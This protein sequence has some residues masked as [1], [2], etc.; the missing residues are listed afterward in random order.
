M[1]N[2]TFNGNTANDDGDG[3]YNFSSSSPTVTNCILWGDSAP[4]G[5]EIYSYSGCTPEV[6]YSCIQGI[7]IPVSGNTGSNPLFVNAPTNVR[8][9]AGS[10]CIDT[11][12]PNGAPSIDIL[13]VTRPQGNGYDMGAY[14][15]KLSIIHLP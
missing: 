2:C 6:T 12:T 9:Q 13:G 1:T 10:P 4:S 11:G 7:F 14:E 5:N 8:L 15:F 3:M